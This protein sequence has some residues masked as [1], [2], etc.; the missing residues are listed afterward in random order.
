MKSWTE[1][2]IAIVYFAGLFIALTT[3]ILVVL[4]LQQFKSVIKKLTE[5]FD[6]LWHRGFISTIIIAG[7]LGAM[8]VS[9]RNC[10]GEYDY[11]LKS[12]NATI[13]KGLEQVSSSFTYVSLVLGLWLIIFLI[14]SLTRNKNKMPSN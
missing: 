6:I 7:L 10:N 4:Y 11:L 9:F 12:E 3:S 8:A 13:S 2:H 1:F 14:L 5:K